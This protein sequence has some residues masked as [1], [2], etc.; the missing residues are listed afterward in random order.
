MRLKISKTPRRGRRR[1]P[2]GLMCS[3]EKINLC[4]ARQ[5]PSWWTHRRENRSIITISGE[6]SSVRLKIT[7]VTANADTNHNRI[8]DENAQ[9]QVE[10][11]KNNAQQ[12]NDEPVVGFVLFNK[13]FNISCVI[14]A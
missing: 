7:S 12:F 11:A 5:H 4:Q 9:V 14:E 13:L 8:K 1:G 2:D 3:A 10:A 6:R